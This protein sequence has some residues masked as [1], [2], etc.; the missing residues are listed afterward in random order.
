MGKAW[1]DGERSV[2]RALSGKR[3]SHQS[4]GKGGPDVVTDRLTIE[5]KTRKR[6]PLLLTRGLE[7]AARGAQG[8]RMPALV[9][10]GPWTRDPIICLR[11]SALKK[12]LAR[13]GEEEDE[14]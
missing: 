10:R 6:P 11:L 5:V 8:G 7:Q 1:K 9:L 2:A 12:L 13:G 4:Q 14:N 3:I